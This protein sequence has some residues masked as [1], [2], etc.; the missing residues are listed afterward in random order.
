MIRIALLLLLLCSPLFAE[1]PLTWLSKEAK[2]NA[3]LGEEIVKLSFKVSNKTKEAIEISSAKVTCD[4]MSVTSKFP[5]LVQPGKEVKI[6]AEYETIGKL[7]LNRGRIL[8]DVEG[9]KETLLVEVTIPEA[10]T[11]SPR[12][13]IWKKEARAAKKIVVSLHKDWQGTIDSVFCKGDGVKVKLEKTTNG[14]SIQV[15]PSA[16]MPKKRTWV[17]IKGKDPQGKANEYR[18]YLI[19]N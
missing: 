8:L 5:L 9:K 2:A 6:H 17:I 7:G 14:A 19:F 3:D 11:V 4:C 15:S 18:V 1:S 10:V 16:N 12:F 13:L